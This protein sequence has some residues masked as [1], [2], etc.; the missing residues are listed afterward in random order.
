MSLDA[1]I[2]DCMNSDKQLEEC[3][4]RKGMDEVIINDLKTERSFN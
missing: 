2:Y 4:N 1:Q 3:E